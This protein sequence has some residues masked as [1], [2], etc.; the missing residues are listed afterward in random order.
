MGFKNDKNDQRR[1]SQGLLVSYQQPHGLHLAMLRKLT[2]VPA[3]PLS[4]KHWETPG[5]GE[6]SD[7][8]THLSS[9]NVKRIIP[10]IASLTWKIME[11]V[12]LEHI[13]EHK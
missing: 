13:S 3:R 7:N 12:L 10:V 8:M 11:W 1:M 4:Y 2:D 9:V 6:I 5:S